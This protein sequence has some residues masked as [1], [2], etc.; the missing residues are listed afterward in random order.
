MAAVCVQAMILNK[1][2]LEESGDCQLAI[3]EK[4]LAPVGLTYG[5]AAD[6]AHALE[7]RGQPM[8]LE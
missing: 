3:E 2:G 7:I 8:P 6:V 1:S 5:S 4:T